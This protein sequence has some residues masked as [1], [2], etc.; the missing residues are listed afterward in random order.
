[1]QISLIKG[2]IIMGV[3]LIAASLVLYSDITRNDAPAAVVSNTENDS[4]AYRADMV[5]RALKHQDG[6]ALAALAHPTKG[7]RFSPY[8]HIDLER[9]IVVPAIRLPR[10]YAQSKKE[11][12]GV[13][14]G[15]GAPIELTF[16]EY[17]KKFLYDEDFANAPQRATNKIIG[18]GNTII[19]IDTAY[20]QGVFVEYYFPGFDPQYGGMDWKSLRLIFQRQGVTWY[21]VGISHDQWTI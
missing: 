18:Q 7:V 9:D 6:A 10:A 2:S 19:N 16:L 12:W 11:L 3:V 1:M 15:S 5:V 17:S 8:G 14:D 4:V 20:P 13:Y 21:L